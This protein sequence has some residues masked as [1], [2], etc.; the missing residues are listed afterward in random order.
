M[1]TYVYRTTDL[2][3]TWTSLFTED[4]E[5]YA[6]V[7]REDLKQDQLLFLGTEFGLYIS[8]N[9]GSSWARFTGNL[10]KVAVRDLVIHPRDDDLVI[11]TH[12]RSVYILDDITPLR[13]LTT[14]VLQSD[15]A[16]L[17][18]R[19]AT[20]VIQN[21]VAGFSFSG[22]DEF[23]AP[24]PPEAAFIHYYLKKRHIFG[25]LKIEV[26]GSDGELITTLPGGKR[27]GINRVLWP[28]RLKPPKM[29]PGNTL[30]PAFTGPR[31][32]EGSYTF[33]LIKGKQTLEGQVELVADP[34]STHSAEDRALQQQTAMK[35]YRLLEDLTYTADTL[36]DL[37]NQAEE[38]NEI[39]SERDGLRRRLE[40]YAKELEDLRKVLVAT[41]P[42]GWLS[43]EEQ[44]REKLSNLFG[45]IN[46]YEGKPTHSQ[47]EQIDVLATELE[48]KKTTFET[49]T[50]NRLAELNTRLEKKKMEP[51][52]KLSREE[53]L[54]KQES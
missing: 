16:L 24:N 1:T 22:S 52:S 54:K 44:L 18:S 14:D 51:L 5:G 38:R 4:V 28:M 43:G 46:G 30:T 12:G 39:L 7:I 15:V 37:T 47:L 49:L 32:A 2:G 45:A 36:M 13:H 34:R 53:W 6:L 17:P 48:A 42:A 35:L 25:D 11:A 21:G 26:Y 50:G 9:G 33:K 31:V 29:P 8:I 3:N 40:G 10:P 23:I 19:P 20:M 41:H 27:V